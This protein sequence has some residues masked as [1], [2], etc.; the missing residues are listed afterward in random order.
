MKNKSTLGNFSGCSCH[1]TDDFNVCY[2]K[3]K[4]PIDWMEFNPKV[5]MVNVGIQKPVPSTNICNYVRW[6]SY[7]DYSVSSQTFIPG[8][9]N[10][11]KKIIKLVPE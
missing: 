11:T 6:T 2:P 9:K 7:Y 10:H 4:I 8:V 3:K 1:T 5:L